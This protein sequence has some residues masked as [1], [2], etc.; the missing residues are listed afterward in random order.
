LNHLPADELSGW[1]NVEDIKKLKIENMNL[2]F[3]HFVG[4]YNC[5]KVNTLFSPFDEISINNYFLS[6]DLFN[7]FKVV[8]PANL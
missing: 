3:V 5:I 8:W 2:E 7:M 1:K 4:L 6:Q